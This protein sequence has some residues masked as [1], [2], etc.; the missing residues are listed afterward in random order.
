MLTTSIILY[1]LVLTPILLA[2]GVPIGTSICLGSV[3][4]M[5]SILGPN[6]PLNAAT[7]IFSG[8]NNF[9]LLAIPFFVLAG[10][11]MNSG[12][13]ARILINFAKI[14]IGFIPG[15]LMH[16][17][18]VSNMLFGAISGSGVAA[19]AAIGSVILPGE[20]AE[21]YDEKLSAVVN[22]SSAPAGMIIPPSN[23]FI[24]YSLAS[25][26]VSVAALFVAGYIPGIMWGL[27][28][29]VVAAYYAWKLKYKASKMASLQA[30]LQTSALA[31]PVLF[32]IFIII[33]GIIFGWFT[34][35]EASCVAVV[36]A[37]GL[38]Y[39]YGRIL[40][41]YGFDEVFHTSQ[42]PGMLLSTAKTT[43]L[44]VFLIGVSAVLGYVL[45]FAKLPN[46]IATSLLNFSDNPTVILLGMM[47]IML[48][49]GCV[50][51]PAPAVLI[52]TPIF[53]PVA[54]K[55]GIHPVHF[56]VMMVFNLSIGAITPP[57]GPILFTG[58][59]I[60]R[61]SI[62]AVFTKMLP[63]FLALIIVLVIV[64]LVP[65]LSLYLPEAAGLLK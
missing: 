24:I 5:A 34:P 1:L 23:I 52:F 53:L 27:A 8:I 3:F 12:G 32:L 62:D 55:L 17:N 48:L 41:K 21:G 49:V 15:S 37:L 42:L 18:I 64:T 46:M 44:I 56:G 26:G 38:S 29:M 20:K 57:V 35:T 4:S 39:I 22:I 13:L 63:F 54:V 14:F 6:A 2:L 30:I 36:Y 61:Q 47:I 19:A 11:I 65:A 40:P 31:V 33:F 50:M 58:C 25:G 45:A 43:G 16:T 60:A 9:T 59:R 51:D 28:V 10:N 7:K